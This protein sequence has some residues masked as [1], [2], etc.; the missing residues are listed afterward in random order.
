MG[1][2]IVIDGLDG[3][4]KATQTQMLLQHFHQQH[5]PAKAITFPNYE[6][7]S[8]ELVKMY[9]NGEIAGT[10]QEVNAYAAASFYACDRYISYLT[11]WKKDYQEGSWILADRYVSSNAIH[12]M[13]KLPKA[14]WDD[15][16]DWIYE[17]E[18]HL[19]G[20][21]REN[22]LIYLD[23][24]PAISHKLLSNRYLGDEWKRDFHERDCNYLL[25]C[26]E[27]A[28]YAAE[29]KHWEIVRCDNGV[30]ACSIPEI[31]EQIRK[32]IEVFLSVC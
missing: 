6:S 19:L 14:E 11:E 32:K 4:G 10:A 26:R 21:P 2:L 7:R 22:Q 9:L 27:A 28:Y 25:R 20:L 12:Q 24:D 17:Y 16:L 30:A 23:M 3:S 8:S 1:R 29:K 5:L 13:V 18:Y 15:F 31:F